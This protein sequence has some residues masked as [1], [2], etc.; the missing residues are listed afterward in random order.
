[1]HMF[2]THFTGHCHSLLSVRG[3][4]FVF[5]DHLYLQLPPES[6]QQLLS[7]PADLA[8][9]LTSRIAARTLRRMFL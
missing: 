2:E 1:M 8:G 7:L 4:S 3:N 9:R 6:Q 5:V